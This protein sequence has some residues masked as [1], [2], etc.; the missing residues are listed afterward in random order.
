MPFLIILGVSSFIFKGALDATNQNDLLMMT[1]FVSSLTSS[2]LIKSFDEIR[3]LAKSPEIRNKDTSISTKKEQLNL[4]KKFHGIIA[5]VTLLDDK[6]ELLT[7]THTHPR[8]D[9]KTS[10]CYLKAREGTY[11]LSN[12]HVI[13]DP[14][15]TRMLF[16]V[17]VFNEKGFSTSILVGE[18]N[19]NVLSDLI[20]SS[21][22]EDP[23][24]LFVVD[25][26]GTIIAHQD[27]KRILSTLN[28]PELIDAI[29]QE[30]S[31]VEYSLNGENWLATIVPIKSAGYLD[32][33]SWFAMTAMSKRD[34]YWLF[35][36]GVF[37]ASLLGGGLILLMLLIGLLLSRR[38][39]H[40]VVQV[41]NA[42]FRVSEGDYD[43]EVPV[44]SEDELGQLAMVFNRMTSNISQNTVPKHKFDQLVYQ[45]TRDLKIEYEKMK[46]ALKRLKKE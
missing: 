7:S 42:A 24:Q 4:F 27:K 22:N 3:F 38:M 43:V 1:R 15:R 9:L 20:Q 2:E 12:V 32:S 36:E 21:S 46:Q 40:P 45:K 16:C 44:E 25:L 14:P 8:D 35:D 11:G 10:S 41:S 31:F 18:M 28:A 13:G 37:I 29:R 5:G 39:V 6:G 19:T 30:K 23:N 26:N 34:L 17:P 33:P